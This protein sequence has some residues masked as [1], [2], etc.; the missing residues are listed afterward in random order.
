MARKLKN[1]LPTP[2]SSVQIGKRLATTR[3]S[4]GLTQSQLAELIGINQRLVSDYEIGRTHISAEMLARF[5]SV[6]RC[7]ADSLVSAKHEP[8]SGM[9]TL[10]LARRLKSIEKLPP[11][12]Q[13]VLLQNIDMFLKGA[14]QA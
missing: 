5:C 1:T 6:L 14:T 7:S 12:Q 4:R 11:G 10:R 13:K 8:P 9:L 2:F 3:K